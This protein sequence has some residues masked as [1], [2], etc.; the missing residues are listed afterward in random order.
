[1]C[2]RDRPGTGVMS[3]AA[4]RPGGGDGQPVGSQTSRRAAIDR[5]GWG[6]VA[7]PAALLPRLQSHRAVLGQ[8]QGGFAG[9]EN[10]G[11]RSAGEGRGDSDRRRYASQRHRLVS[12]LWVFIIGY[13][14]PG[15]ALA[16]EVT[17]ALTSAAKASP[18]S[19]ALV[20]TP[21]RRAPPNT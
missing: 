6:G 1:M 16:A 3:S 7:L 12:P 4:P 5:A 9:R 18:F 14:Y 8:D 11:G 21:E 10:P 13:S 15:T 17:R 19:A 20:C 2:I